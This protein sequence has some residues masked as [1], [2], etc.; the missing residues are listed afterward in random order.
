MP[1]NTPN[2]SWAGIGE[3]WSTLMWAFTDTTSL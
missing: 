3:N 2:Q 1:V